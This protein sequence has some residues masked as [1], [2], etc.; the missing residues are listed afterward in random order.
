M[1]DLAQKVVDIYREY[2][3]PKQGD[4]GLSKITKITPDIEKQILRNIFGDGKNVKP[5]GRW[6]ENFE[7]ACKRIAE[8]PL[9]NGVKGRA[10]DFRWMIRAQFKIY[11]ILDGKFDWGMKYKREVPENMSDENDKETGKIRL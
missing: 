5:D 4:V 2:E 7:E 3:S 1:R 9:C 8:N 6:V 11:E 10:I